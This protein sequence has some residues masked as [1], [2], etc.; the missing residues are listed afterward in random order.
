MGIVEEIDHHGE[1][2]LDIFG[3]MEL[4]ETLG[5]V[6]ARFKVVKLPSGSNL[7]RPTKLN[8]STEIQDLCIRIRERA[9]MFKNDGRQQRVLP[10]D[11][12]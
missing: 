1:E 11:L 6:D 8:A 7:G 4:G 3:C 12:R 2:T 5:I 9:F 10:W